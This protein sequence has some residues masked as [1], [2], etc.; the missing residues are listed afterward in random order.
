MPVEQ[1]IRPVHW[2]GSSWKDYTAFPSRVQEECGFALYLAQIGQRPLRAKALK[3]MGSGVVELIEVFDGDTFRTV[4]TVRFK[5]AVYVVHAFQ[6][7]SKT[8][9]KTDQSDIDLIKRRLR[10]AQEHYEAAYGKETS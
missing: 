5:Q 3:G 10:D 1:P 4:Y 8:G 7:K 6:K 9:I 2:I